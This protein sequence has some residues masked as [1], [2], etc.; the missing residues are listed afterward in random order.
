MGID[1]VVGWDAKL[2]Q[3][4]TKNIPSITVGRMGDTKCVFNVD[5]HSA[6]SRYFFCVKRLGNGQAGETLWFLTPT[7]A[8]RVLQCTIPGRIVRK[9]AENHRQIESNPI[10][11][12]EGHTRKPTA[13]RLVQPDGTVYCCTI[14]PDTY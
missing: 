8:E 4:K 9:W 6:L 10:W 3:H 11:W 14:D 1:V 12:V 7:D 5:T 13:Y 2:R